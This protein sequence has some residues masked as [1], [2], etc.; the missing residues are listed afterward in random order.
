[1]LE[2]VRLHLLPVAVAAILS[3]TAIPVEIGTGTLRTDG[4]V[5]GDF[6]ANLLL[7]LPLG[8][9]L[10]RHRLLVVLAIA[11]ALSCTIELAQL[12]SVGRY[13]SPFD[14]LANALSGLTGA[15][16]WKA[17]RR[18]GKPVTEP[19]SL[20]PLA[21]VSLA[22]LCVAT[23]AAWLRPGVSSAVVGWDPSYALVLGNERRGGRGWEG[24]IEGF[25]LLPE[26]IRGDKALRLS[27]TPPARWRDVIP[28]ATLLDASHQ[29]FQ[30][31]ASLPLP[32]EMARDLTAAATAANALTIVARVKPA[33]LQPPGAGRI[34]S[35]SGDG[36]DRNFDFAQRGNRA[37]FRIRTPISGKNT[38]GSF[39]QSPPLLEARTMTLVA[40]YDGAVSRIYVDG[41]LVA[42]RNL[43]A[44]GCVVR[45]IC[46]GGAHRAWLVI[47]ATAVVLTIATLG[48]VSPFAL[49]GIG[50]GCGAVLSTIVVALAGDTRIVPASWSPLLPIAG[51][52]T[53][54]VAIHLARSRTAT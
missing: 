33:S 45:A 49:W 30:Q 42:R 47:G 52:L 22:V 54:V 44:A 50:L 48:V 3:V 16:L 18:S 11:F 19:F 25:A 8:V 24:V 27:S 17:L 10:S 34:V 46:D 40:S 5:A 39:V 23:V 9:A 26:A 14:V 37:A 32:Q 20:R 29:T 53:V 38:A 13:T 2:P 6:V 4:P 41:K 21:Q 28:R 31:G 1:M 35:F 15:A 43:A 36:S 12:W 7:F 51:A